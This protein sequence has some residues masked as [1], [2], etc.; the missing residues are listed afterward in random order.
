MSFFIANNISLSRINNHFN[1]SKILFSA[2][3]LIKTEVDKKIVNS[4]MFSI[5]LF[6]FSLFFI[7]S[8]FKTSNSY[9]ILGVFPF[10][11]KSHSMMFEPVMK[12]LAKRGHQVDVVSHFP[13]KEPLKYYNDISLKGT[14]PDLQNNVTFELIQNFSDFNWIKDVL[15]MKENALCDILGHPVIQTLINQ[16]AKNGPYDLVISEVSRSF[17]FS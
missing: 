16:R 11:G 17:I 8:N 7:I 5:K 1:V 4:T 2:W 12:E 10:N 15:V 14:S 3:L 9:K 13:L 6:S